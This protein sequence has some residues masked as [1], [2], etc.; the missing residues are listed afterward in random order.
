[1]QH[2]KSDQIESF[3]DK[4]RAQSISLKLVEARWTKSILLGQTGHFCLDQVATLLELSTARVKALSY[5]IQEKGGNALTTIGAGF[6]QNRW[7]V[8]M[9]VFASFYLE[10]LIPR[11]RMVRAEW[12]GNQLLSQEGIFYLT[13]ICRK[14][15]FTVQQ[16]RHQA[17]IMPDSRSTCGIWLDNEE[18]VLLADMKIFGPWITDIWLLLILLTDLIDVSFDPRHLHAERFN[19]IFEIENPVL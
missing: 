1:M 11:V 6:F 18:K 10:H 2:R 17:R 12:D 8:D 13:D 16:L 19:N 4:D 7:I 9:P 14:I 15:P 3:A 5:E